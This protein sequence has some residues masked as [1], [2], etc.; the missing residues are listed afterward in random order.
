MGFGTDVIDQVTEAELAFGNELLPI[1][2]DAREAG[3]GRLGLRDFTGPEHFPELVA[4]LRV[5]GYDGRT[6]RGHP[7]GQPQARPWPRPAALGL[8]V[9]PADA[10]GVGEEVA[11]GERVRR[12]DEQL[13]DAGDPGAAADRRDDRRRGRRRSSRRRS[14]PRT[15]SRSR[16]RASSSRRPS[17]GRARGAP[18]GAPRGRSRSPSGRAGR[19]RRRPRSSSPR[20]RPATA[21]RS[22]R[23]SRRRS[24]GSPD[25]TQVSCSRA[26]A[27]IRSPAS[28]SS[29]A[30]RGSIAKPSASASAI[31][32]HMPRRRRRR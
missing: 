22:G 23:C 3:G 15:S 28:E 25:A 14:A 26:A 2:V 19:A 7:V 27:R 4:A 12:V 29:R 6:A 9:V 1:V 16:T 13:P 17:S 11:L 21:R 8:C 24:P 5:R 30:S 18:P 20:R 10:P 32:Y 31:A